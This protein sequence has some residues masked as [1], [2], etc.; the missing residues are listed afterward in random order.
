MVV[1]HPLERL[2][3]AYHDKFVTR[4]TSKVTFSKYKKKILHAVHAVNV[5]KPVPVTFQHF[6]QY[7]TMVNPAKFDEHWQLYNDRCAPCTIEYDYIAKLETMSSDLPV[8]LQ[9]L[10]KDTT[11]AGVPASMPVLKALLW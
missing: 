11:T 5:S 1:R 10:S 8:L 6:I 7:L 9:R 4:K 3:S 2:A